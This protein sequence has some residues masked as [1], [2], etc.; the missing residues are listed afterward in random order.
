MDMKRLIARVMMFVAGIVLSLGVWAQSDDS[1]SDVEI[2]GLIKK[3]MTEEQKAILEAN[4]ATNRK[5]R[6]AFKATLTEEQKAL[7]PSGRPA[8]ITLE[9]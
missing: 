3:N 9:E 2:R 8:N 6:E 4:R 7:Q 1:V 5:M